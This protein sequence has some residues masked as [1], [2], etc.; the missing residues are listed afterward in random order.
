MSITKH[1]ISFDPADSDDYDTVASYLKAA[2]GT[3][4]THTGAALDV[5]IKTSDI[6][7]DV[8]SDHTE[9]S[10]RLG[11]GT[12]FYTS[13]SENGDISLD[14]HISNS[15]LDIRDL[16]FATDSVDVSGS[17]ISLDAATLAAL[18]SVTVSAT[19]LDIRDLDSAQDSVEIATAAGQAL[20]IESDGSL[21]VN[22]S[23]AGYS[24]CSNATKAIAITATDIVTSELTDRKELTIQN[25]GSKDVYIGCDNTVTTSNGLLVPKGATASFRFGPSINVHAIADGGVSE[26]RVLELA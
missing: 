2:D 17:E 21:N 16:A 4:I 20:T 19:D 18:E 10:V 9:D 24:A 14:V 23:E 1:K 3:L 6:A 26:L 22:S 12:A 7:I 13:T 25:V 8:E 11:D 15:D 5:N